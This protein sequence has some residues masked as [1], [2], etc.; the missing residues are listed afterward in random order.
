[1]TNPYTTDDYWYDRGQ[2]VPV[3]SPAAKEN[4]DREALAELF[5]T[6]AYPSRTHASWEE[7]RGFATSQAYF[8]GAERIL[9]SDWY[10]GKLLDTRLDALQLAAETLAGVIFDTE[11]DP[12]YQSKSHHDGIRHAID[13]IDVIA[14]KTKKEENNNDNSLRYG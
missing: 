4:P 2:G 3:K 6:L 11:N 14:Q 8:R 9:D 13:E 1:M 10:R 7:V 12:K 5:Y